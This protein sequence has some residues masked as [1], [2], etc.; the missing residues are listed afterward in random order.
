MRVTKAVALFVCG[1]A[2]Q[3]CGKFQANEGLSTTDK[4]S[5]SLSMFGGS[6]LVNANSFYQVADQQI[7]PAQ[8]SLMFPI[9]GYPDLAPSEYTALQQQATSKI[10]LSR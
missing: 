3:G 6:G 7:D 4:N 9:E 10:Q 5:N 1:L 2:L 8:T